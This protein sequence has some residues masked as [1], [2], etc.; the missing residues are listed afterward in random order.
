MNTKE[1]MTIINSLVDDVLAEKPETLDDA[2]ELLHQ[3]VD[4]T[5]TVIYYSQAWEL[6][7]YLRDYEP[8][9]LTEYEAQAAD[10]GT[11]SFESLNHYCT[12]IAYWALF[13]PAWGLIE[14]E[15]EE[16]A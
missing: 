11:E 10:V 14:K 15:M 4:G 7:K 12:I 1:Y 5:S 9:D 3:F 6:I 16:M 8:A 13:T 2:M